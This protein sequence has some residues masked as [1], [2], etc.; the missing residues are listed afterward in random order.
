MDLAEALYNRQSIHKFL[1]LPVP[2]EFIGRIADAGRVAPTAG[3]LQPCRFIIVQD[4]AK[5]SAIADASAQQ[6]W[7]E[8]AP[9]FIVI[10]TE[11]N[12]SRRF[13]NKR[14]DLYA[15]QDAAMAAMQMQ[16]MAHSLKLGC[17]FISAFD[18]DEIKKV[19]NVPENVMVQGVLIIGYPAEKT[20]LAIEISQ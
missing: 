13:Y 15:T 17:T 19:T 1:D 3:N 4:E 7:M 5:R 16:L 8:K 11:N 6:H 18:S 12:I 20:Y 2:W 14:G 10:V 9:V